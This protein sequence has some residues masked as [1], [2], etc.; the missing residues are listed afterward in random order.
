MTLSHAA[1]EHL[2]SQY[3]LGTL[4]GGARRRF[5]ALL[6]SDVA[7]QTLVNNWQLRL[8]PLYELQ[9]SYLPVTP[10]AL[11]WEKLEQKLNLKISTKPEATI[12]KII[13]P[14]FW[15]NC[16]ATLRSIKLWS[17]QGFVGASFALGALVLFSVYTLNTTKPT[18]PQYSATL[19]SADQT[20]MTISINQDFKSLELTWAASSTASIDPKTQVL[21]LWAIAPPDTKLPPQSLGLITHQAGQGRIAI[22]AAIAARLRHQT[23]ALAISLE[24]LGGSPLPNAPSGA[25]IYQ[26]AWVLGGKAI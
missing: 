19:K 4:R 2:A 3:A 22:P 24:P 12:R 16:I 9:P 23:V 11:V 1:L 14:T 20:A 18:A 17:A 13:Q 6:Q 15:E 5:E 26:G 10:P 21:E 25:V 7:L 8:Q